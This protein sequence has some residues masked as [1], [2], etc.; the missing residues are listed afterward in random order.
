M[1]DQNHER[2]DRLAF[3][4]DNKHAASHGVDGLDAMT[5]QFNDAAEQI[6]Q[7]CGIRPDQVTL[8]MFFNWLNNP[9]V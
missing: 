2:Q 3:D 7:E 5:E 1:S 8:Q 4:P 9:D 6:A